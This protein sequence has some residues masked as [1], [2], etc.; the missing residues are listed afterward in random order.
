L[1]IQPAGSSRD[2]LVPAIRE[3]NSLVKHGI[4]KS[5]L[6][7]ALN[8][9]GNKNEEMAAREFINS[10]GYSVLLGCL[11]ERPSYRQAQNEGK[12]VTEIQ[13]KSLKE[14]ANEILQSIINKLIINSK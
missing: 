5:K 12:A 10:S 9:I 2:D 11:Q 1:T 7:F 8:H 14:K 4:P 13:Y 3:F 6:I